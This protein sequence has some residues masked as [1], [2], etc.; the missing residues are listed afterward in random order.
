MEHLYRQ[1]RVRTIGVANYLIPFLEELNTYA[2]VVPAVNQVEFSPYLYLKDLLHYC[3]ERNIQLQAYSPIA[4]G[5]KFQDPRI[6]KLADKYG[7]TPAQ[8]LLRWDIEHGVSAIPKSS[9]PGRLKENFDIFDFSLTA[10][11][12]ALMDSFHEN[13]RIVGDPMHML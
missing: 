11:D 2:T 10:A 13:F 6:K 4:R 1:Q 3:R 9:N 12:V 8:L 5:Q 7:K